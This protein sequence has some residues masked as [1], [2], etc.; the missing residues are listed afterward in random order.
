MLKF[1][2]GQQ[3][4]TLLELLVTVAILGVLLG[5][6]APNYRNFVDGQKVRSVLNEWKSAFYFAQSEALRLKDGVVF[7][8]ADASGKNCN[9][10]NDFSNGWLVLHQEG[11]KVE[12]L[13]DNIFENQNINISLEPENFNGKL[14]FFGNGRVDINAGASLVIRSSSHTSKLKIS[15]GGRLRETKE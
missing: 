3:G 10:R 2:R 8:S 14:N 5:I 11:D 9:N 12:I 1:R 6:A 15:S 13:Q 7:C 4:F